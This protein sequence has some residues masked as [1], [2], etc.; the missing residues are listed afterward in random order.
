MKGIIVI[1]SFWII[2]SG[3]IFIF[4]QLYTPTSA[5]CSYQG[6]I[7]Q[8]VQANLDGT[9]RS[10]DPET[11]FLCVTSLSHEEITYNI[12]LDD[13]FKE[14]DT[15]IEQYLHTLEDEKDI[16]FWPNR[17]A[18]SFDAL[19]A[20]ERKFAVYGE[21]WT[22]YRDF[23]DPAQPNSIAQEVLACQGD[24]TSYAQVATYFPASLCMMLVED[25][26]AIYHQVAINI[27]K[28]NK[29]AVQ[30]NEKKKYEIQ[31]QTKYDELMDQVNYNRSYI[32]RVWQG[33]PAKVK[34]AK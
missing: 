32:E 3:G 27:L 7:D 18:T 23:C 12:I 8:C 26:L 19:N 14:I 21:Y 15:E 25:K 2:V 17:Q 33:W 1:L 6:K 34:T 20:F 9:A 5:S 4:S 16:Y 31:E 29:G 22:R 28:L 30:Q 11:E 13:K 24:A 10:I